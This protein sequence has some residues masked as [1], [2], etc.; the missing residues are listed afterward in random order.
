MSFKFIPLLLILF[1][2]KISYAATQEVE[3]KKGDLSISG[4]FP[5][6]VS[7]AVTLNGH[8]KKGKTYKL[9]VTPEMQSKDIYKMTYQLSYLGNQSSGSVIV[10]PGVE[11]KIEMSLVK[12]PKATSQFSIK[13][14]P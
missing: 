8:D 7:E 5:F 1:S 6:I 10:K 12:Q 3:L 11:S 2:F 9:V 4:K 13:I 14:N